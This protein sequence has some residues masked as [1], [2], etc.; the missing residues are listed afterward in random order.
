MVGLRVVPWFTKLPSFS[1]LHCTDTS[2]NYPTV[3]ELN[4]RSGKKNGVM[5]GAFGKA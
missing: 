1:G 4:V 3:S 5:E 2:L